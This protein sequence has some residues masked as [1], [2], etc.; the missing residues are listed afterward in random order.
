MA[1]QPVDAETMAPAWP[2]AWGEESELSMAQRR[3]V[4]TLG[5]SMSE[6]AVPRRAE[7]PVRC[8][9]LSCAIPMDP[10]W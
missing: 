2:K 7:I 3:P 9:R 1:R 10:T 8:K 4:S 6:L 5:R